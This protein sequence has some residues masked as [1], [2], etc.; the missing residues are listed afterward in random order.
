MRASISTL[1]LAA[2]AGLSPALAQS[3][4]DGGAYD[5]S[6]YR[7][8]YFT[9]D[10]PAMPQGKVTPEPQNDP[11]ADLPRLPAP[12]AA[13]EAPTRIAAAQSYRSP[14]SRAARQSEDRQVGVMAGQQVPAG[15][16]YYTSPLRRQRTAGSVLGGRIEA[17]VGYDMVEIANPAPAEDLKSEGVLYGISG[18]Y[19]RRFGNMFIGGFA[20]VDFSEASEMSTVSDS[21]DNG[22]GTVT[23]TLIEM[24]SGMD[25]DIE[26]GV[27]GGFTTDRFRVYA[28]AALTNAVRTAKTTT[29]ETVT[30]A[31]DPDN[32]ETTVNGP[33]E[34]PEARFFD[35]G[36]RVGGGAEV[37]LTRGLYIKAEYRYS[38]YD[39]D[40]TRHQ[41][42]TGV[43]LRF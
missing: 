33:T 7:D 40:Y 3:A 37:S 35:D 10:R 14:Q 2:A 31:T 41:A 20:S 42:V 11:L 9:S 32:P 19:D 36:W 38:Q 1:V 22:A 29:T 13:P 8:A 4:D 43:G 23:E 27:R 24:E 26:V 16:P 21:F 30:D 39:E 15:T 25:R 5:P 12:E 18:G 6:A 34:A 28:L 17:R